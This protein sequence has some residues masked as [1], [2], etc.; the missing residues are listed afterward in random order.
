MQFQL[1]ITSSFVIYHSEAEVIQP[2]PVTN[3]S[4][5]KRKRCLLLLLFL[6]L[7]ASSAAIAGVLLSKLEK[8]GMPNCISIA[9]KNTFH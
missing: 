3:E 5:R 1:V 2:T 7:L 6:L 8:Y 4:K 9:N